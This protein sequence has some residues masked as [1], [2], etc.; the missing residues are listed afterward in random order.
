M[1][2]KAGRVGYSWVEMSIDGWCI[3]GWCALVNF[4]LS[5]CLARAWRHA[6][7]SLRGPEGVASVD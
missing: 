7:E 5:T 2:D 3:S 1:Q 6:V 4:I